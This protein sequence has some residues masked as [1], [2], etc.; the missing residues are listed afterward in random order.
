MD[1]LHSAFTSVGFVSYRNHT[2]ESFKR[3]NRKHELYA[4][5]II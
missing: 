3:D 1:Q 4:D 5:D 2:S